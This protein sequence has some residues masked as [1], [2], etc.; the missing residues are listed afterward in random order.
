MFD[1]YRI[2]DQGFNVF[3]AMIKGDETFI[4]FK[5]FKGLLNYPLAG[6]IVNPIDKLSK[7]TSEAEGTRDLL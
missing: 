6:Q 4:D 2:P 7:E 1:R 5:R 3:C